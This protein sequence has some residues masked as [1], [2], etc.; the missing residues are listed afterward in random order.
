MGEAATF[1]LYSLPVIGAVASVISDV[2]NCNLKTPGAVLSCLSVPVDMVFGI[3]DLQAL[4]G[5][6][7][8]ASQHLVSEYGRSCSEFGVFDKTFSGMVKFH[9]KKN[10]KTK[11]PPSRRIQFYWIEF[12]MSLLNPSAH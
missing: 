3:F 2:F 12:A 4:G 6:A 1:G 5:A 10:Q 9:S 8:G 11:V 7:I